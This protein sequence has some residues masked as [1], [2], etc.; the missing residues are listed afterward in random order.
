MTFAPNP[1][2]KSK[3]YDYATGKRNFEG[4]TVEAMKHRLGHGLEG[5]ALNCPTR[6]ARWYLKKTKPIRKGRKRF[7]I[8]YKKNYEKDICQNTVSSWL[9]QAVIQAHS[10]MPAEAMKRLQVK[11]HDV[12]AIA[13]STAFYGNVALSEIL[14]AA[15]WASQTTFTSFYLK[16]VSQDLE[17]INRL[18]PVIVAQAKL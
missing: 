16:D 14:K 3:N 18:G 1:K 5:E 12:R 11:A 2:F 9:K 8:S 6:S 13:T 17:G 10:N 7:F 4:F 15:R